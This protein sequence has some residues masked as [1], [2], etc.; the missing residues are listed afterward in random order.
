MRN[1]TI[2]SPLLGLLV[3]IFSGHQ[4]GFW[5]DQLQTETE[6]PGNMTAVFT[7]SGKTD[8]EILP[9][10]ILHEVL[11]FIIHCVSALQ[12]LHARKKQHK[13]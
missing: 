1:P 12:L 8:A 5:I 11:R 3:F 10:G 9:D 4:T 13:Y 7:G 2:W 6:V